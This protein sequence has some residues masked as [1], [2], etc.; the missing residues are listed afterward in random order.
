MVGQ[1]KK[2]NKINQVCAV[3]DKVA[4]FYNTKYKNTP[5]LINDF[6]KLVKKNGKILDVG[7]GT[8][9]DAHYM[10]CKGFSVVGIDVSKKMIM[11]AKNN[12]PKT[13]FKVMSMTNLKLNNSSFDGIFV[14][15][16]LIHLSKSEIDKILNKFF[17]FVKR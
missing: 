6:L 16:S 5:T 12:A 13:K 9:K 4:K 10:S 8:G 14:A 11:V 2:I 17:F 15:F 3:Y 7:C 1:S